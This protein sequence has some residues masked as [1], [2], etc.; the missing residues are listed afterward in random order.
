VVRRRSFDLL[1]VREIRRSPGRF[2]SIFLIVFLG[3]GFFAGMR[4]TCPDMKCTCD[5]YLDASYCEDLRVVSLIGFTP[6]EI[7]RIREVPGVEAVQGGFG[8]DALKG[9][10]G[11]ER[12][13]RV[14]SLPTAPDGG[15]AIDAPTLLEGRMPERRGECVAERGR[16]EKMTTRVGDKISLRN[17]QGS[18][19]FSVTGI[20][21]SP[22]YISWERGSN[23]LGS[24]STESYIL[25]TEE[26]AADMALPVIPWMQGI[27][28][29]R[30]CTE[31][32][33]TLKGAAALDSFGREYA[34]LV[35]TAKRRIKALGV[36]L[37]GSDLYWSVQDRNANAGIYG[38]GSDAERI[39]NVGKIFP[40]VFFLVAILVS[41]TAMTRLI[42][43]RRGQIGTL[44]ALGYAD[45]VIIGQ[46]FLYAT[47]ATLGGGLL[48]VAV[49]FPLLPK[50]IYAM[51]RLM[52]DVGPLQ[53]PYIPTLAAEAV[54]LAFLCTTS[55]TCIAGLHELTASP[56]SLMRP[57][58]PKPGKRVLLERVTWLWRR[59]SFLRKVTV[60][61][62]FRYK[63][64]FWMSVVGIAGC[65]GLLVAG[66]GMN[67]SLAA[68]THKQFGTIYHYDVMCGIAARDEKQAAQ[69][70]ASVR[71][72]EGIQE[73]D[74]FYLQG[75]AMNTAR[76]NR[77][78]IDGYI[79]VPSDPAR[80]GNFVTLRADGAEFSLPDD[81]VVLTQKASELLGLTVG[82][83]V[84]LSAA[85]RTAGLRVAAITEHYVMHF[86]Y[87]SP[88]C[89][90][91]YFGQKP[92]YNAVLA[93]EKPVQSG[94][95]S[96]ADRRIGAPVAGIAETAST[97]AEM[98]EAAL[99]NRLLALPGVVGVTFTSQANKV[100]DE[101]MKGMKSIIAI[102]I[103][104]A[105]LLVAV[106]MYNLTEINIEERTK[107][108]AT[109]KVLG[110][111]D[112]E[113]AQY[114]YRENVVL[115]IVGLA[116]GLVF[117]VFLHRSVVLA[118][119]VDVCMFGRNLEPASFLWASLLTLGFATAINALMYRKLA[120][121]DMVEAMKSV[122]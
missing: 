82:D 19:E 3:A 107:E 1:F 34:D 55:A 31:V 46:Y 103:I 80:F 11:E 65:T 89:F 67:D 69:I 33:I 43:E 108:L 32:R 30:F 96:G 40:V 78:D 99:G 36:E 23:S 119:E 61:N 7:E 115:T 57:K 72:A 73:A 111:R 118:A 50:L 116:L 110:F 114:I 83:T 26:D 22:L 91:K 59:F 51:Y 71:S 68:L 121:I 49:G 14:V 98:R 16:T 105:G 35:A 18:W 81:G 85:G 20:V 58:A 70:E 90:G 106:V 64:R 86:A 42:E 63:K 56:A 21:R 41:L 120:R 97:E 95:G 9:N 5:N 48:G 28:T 87:L 74:L 25:V 52:Y 54:F 27:G 17:A 109:I 53:T 45:S 4:A 13:V 10:P 93:V 37:T 44:K 60:R 6:R 122:E 8:V 94:G 47:T 84:Q 113:V 39:G 24:G 12:A 29:D 76:T 92:P 88:V 112:G 101:T 104:A 15:R 66:F 77:S 100:W 62:L 117:G 102:I 79:A 2:I 38:F 75:C